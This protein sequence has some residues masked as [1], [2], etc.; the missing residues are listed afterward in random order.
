ME[1]KR[2]RDDRHLPEG[3]PPLDGKVMKDYYLFTLI[4]IREG[5]NYVSHWGTQF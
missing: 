5:K 4:D 1:S 2:S 3:G